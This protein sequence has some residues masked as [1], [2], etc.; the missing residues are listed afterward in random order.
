[1]SAARAHTA[2]S[3]AH[4]RQVG[5]R[6]RRARN[7]QRSRRGQ[8]L[9]EGRKAKGEGRMRHYTLHDRTRP[10]E[11]YTLQD[12]LDCAYVHYII[13]IGQRLLRDQATQITPRSPQITT[14]LYLPQITPESPQ[15]TAKTT[16]KSPQATPDHQDTL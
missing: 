5:S 4:L 8:T 2:G 1:V 7:P 11:D 3:L 13:Y 15:I 12:K 16:P 10:L 6:G 14:K 9:R